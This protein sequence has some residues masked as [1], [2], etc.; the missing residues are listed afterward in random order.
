MGLL[1]LALGGTKGDDGKRTKWGYG[2]GENRVSALQDMLN[3]G[4]AGRAGDT[5]QGGPVSELLNTIGVRTMGYRDRLAAR[6]AAPARA[7]G[8]GVG[9]KPPRNFDTLSNA[10]SPSF[11]AGRDVMSTVRANAGSPSFR[12]GRDVISATPAVPTTA[13]TPPPASINDFLEFVY[14]GR[15]APAAAPAAA[16]TGVGI[17]E[18][19]VPVAR[20]TAWTSPV[21]QKLDANNARINEINRRM[22]EMQLPLH[23]RNTYGIPTWQF[24]MSQN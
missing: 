13:Q 18:P 21:D 12:A 9:A 23:L 15:S 17:S 16:P 1:D 5:F 10:G 24:Y 4:G 11:R 7:S 19:Y 2:S 14:G 6:Q 22:I 8:G 3:G 20:P